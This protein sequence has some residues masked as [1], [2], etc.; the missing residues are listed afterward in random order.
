M[1]V[2]ARL[3]GL[4][5][6]DSQVNWKADGRVAN[7]LATAALRRL[8]SDPRELGRIL[9]G[10]GE[11]NARGTTE[12]TLLL[13]RHLARHRARLSFLKALDAAAAFD[14]KRSTKP[15]LSAIDFAQWISGA[16]LAWRTFDRAVHRIG[17]H[18]YSINA[19]R[20][21]LSFA[22][23]IVAAIDP[24][25]IDASVAR[26][27]NS[28][29][30]AVIGSAVLPAMF[31][32][33]MLTR[34]SL[35]LSSR[36]PV[37][38]CLAAALH[39]CPIFPTPTLAS[40]RDC[41]RALVGGGI[42]PADAAWMM[43][44]RIKGAIHARYWAQ[45]QLEGNLARLRGIEA[46]PGAAMGGRRNFDA[47]MHSLR[48]QIER[49]TQRLSELAPELEGMLSDLAADWP[50]DGLSDG[51]M[52]SIDYNF[53]ATP[54]IRHR[55]AEKLPHTRNR[56]WLLKKNIAQLC[57]LIGLSRDPAATFDV[58][59]NADDPQLDRVIPWTA[60]SLVLLYAGDH[61]GVGKRT[62][63]L[64]F[65][66]TQAFESL[67]AQP[68]AAARAPM[69]FQS[70]LA[71]AACAYLFALMVV[72]CAPE[73]DRAK[74]EKLNRLTIDHVLI[75]LCARN[76]DARSL[77]LLFKLTART[78][79]QMSYDNDGDNLR[80]QWA[81]AEEL[82]TFARALA[83]WSSSALAEEDKILA[84]ALF[85]RTAE[86][87]L[88]RGARGLQVSRMLT[89]L[90][91]AVSA[92]IEASRQDLVRDLIGLWAEVYKDWQS[93]FPQWANTAETMAAAVERDCS[94]RTTFLAD[95][96][97]AHTHCRRLIEARVGV[98]AQS[99]NVA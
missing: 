1:L 81:V 2:K 30:V 70:A 47:E 99:E 15:Q 33:N 40:F 43:A 98:N 8:P 49:S 64:V 88:S 56:D 89:L 6:S 66:L 52:E 71:R 84:A 58:H 45:H 91:L 54:E 69:R 37:I 7:R 14:S 62:S 57:A 41:R 32:S 65:G 63:D 55:L 97:F 86:L 51:Q 13:T 48:T 76:P 28:L 9:Y 36:I 46:N 67:A 80:R 90:D 72:A 82:P 4:I 50:P 17:H 11:I 27:P 61:R 3:C 26:H 25:A 77:Q 31:D 75:L 19:G 96:S 20:Y 83:L 53:V 35:L 95:P 79:F 73:A 59:F 12:L 74:V 34:A 87:S 78:V 18:D 93:I 24:G 92:S 16:P 10:L 42:D 38:K 21:G 60:Q 44:Y 39:V 85:R 94:E 22:A 23:R 29:R 68:F 5:T